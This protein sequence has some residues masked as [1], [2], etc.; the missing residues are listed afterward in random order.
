MH[1]S[2]LERRSVN[3]KTMSRSV[4]RIWGAEFL[5][6]ALHRLWASLLPVSRYLSLCAVETVTNYLFQKCLSLYCSV[7]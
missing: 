2:K 4:V 5:D 3:T 7:F 6:Q 1:T